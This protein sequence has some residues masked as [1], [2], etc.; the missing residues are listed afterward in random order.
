MPNEE[1]SE[2]EPRAGWTAGRMYAW[3]S[4]RLE[5]VG[6]GLNQEQAKTEA[7]ARL[8]EWQQDRQE[9]SVKQQTKEE[10]RHG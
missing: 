8:C 2:I 1:L 10:V 7:D 5:A 9:K 3:I 6:R 4:F